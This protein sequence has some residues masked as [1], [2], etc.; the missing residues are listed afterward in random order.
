MVGKVPQLCRHGGEGEAAPFRRPWTGRQG[1]TPEKLARVCARVGG[2]TGASQAIE[3][4]LR[5]RPRST[6]LPTL[7]AFAF[8]RTSDSALRMAASC[9]S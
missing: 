9:R 4:L 7:Q 6:L 1:R 8:S 3:G 5:S 2:T